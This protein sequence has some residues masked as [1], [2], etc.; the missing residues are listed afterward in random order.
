MRWLAS[1]GVNGYSGNSYANFGPGIVNR[2]EGMT[3]VGIGNNTFNSNGNENEN[4]GFAAVRPVASIHC[5]YAIN[6]CIRDNIETN[7]V[8]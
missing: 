4:T 1:H 5:G 6:D 2:E 7:Y 8:L 3:L